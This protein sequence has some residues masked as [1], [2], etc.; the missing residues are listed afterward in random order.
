[1]N[2][3]RWLPEN[4]TIKNPHQL[5]TA[6]VAKIQ[7]LESSVEGSHLPAFSL[8]NPHILAYTSYTV[9]STHSTNTGSW[10]LLTREDFDLLYLYTSK[11]LTPLYF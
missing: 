7:V 9:R 8:M 2:P 4:E 5:P 10:P 11:L 3:E 1:M 6:S